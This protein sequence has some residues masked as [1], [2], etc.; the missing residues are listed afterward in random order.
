MARCHPPRPLAAP[1][2]DDVNARGTQADQ[3]P[4]AG[5]QASGGRIVRHVT[6]SSRDRDHP[7]NFRIYVYNR[8]K[9]GRGVSAGGR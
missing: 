9:A 6:G 7:W 5:L 8:E 2:D 1:D 3:G 4:S